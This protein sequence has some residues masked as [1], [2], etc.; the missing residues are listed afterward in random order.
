MKKYQIDWAQFICALLTIGCLVGA[1]VAMFAM[2]R[3]P[4]PITI[5][6]LCGAALASAIVDASYQDNQRRGRK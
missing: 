3:A 5:P 1:L 4:W 2:P 6:L